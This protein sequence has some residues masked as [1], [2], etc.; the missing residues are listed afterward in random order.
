MR[1]VSPRGPTLEGVNFAAS[2]LGA[3]PLTLRTLLLVVLGL[4]GLALGLT[5]RLGWQGK[6]KRNRFVGVRTAATL[7]D[8]DTFRLANQV[9]GVPNLVAGLI[10]VVS[11]VVSF[12]LPSSGGTITVAV[13]GAVGTV[14]VAIGGGLLGHRAAEAV[15]EPEAPKGCGGCA[16][17]AGGCGGLARA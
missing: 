17:G 8:D 3:A 4:V 16:C 2:D 11:A 13:L 7:R 5:G 15:P 9:A 10:A 14:A 1:G 6:L 12:F